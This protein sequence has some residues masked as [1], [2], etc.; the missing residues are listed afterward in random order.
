LSSS[1]RTAPGCSSPRSPTPSPIS[2]IGALVAAH[3]YGTSVSTVIDLDRF[4]LYTE[5]HLQMP[6][7]TQAERDAN[8]TLMELLRFYPIK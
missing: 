3:E 4:R 5:L 1:S 6:N 7:D 2:A 8:A